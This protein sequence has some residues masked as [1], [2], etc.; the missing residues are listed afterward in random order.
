MPEEVYEDIKIVAL[1][2]VPMC[3]WN[4][5]FGCVHEALRPFGIPL[6]HF[7]GAFWE[8]GISNALEEAVA[9]GVDWVLTL[10]YDTMFTP[11]QLDRLIG[12]FGQSPHMDALTALQCKRGTE[13]VPLMGGF[14]ATKVIDGMAHIEINGQPIK[15]KTAHFGLT[16]LRM[17]SLK[18]VPKPW[19]LGLPDG[20]GSYSTMRRT[21]PDIYFWQQWEK[22]G[23]TIYVDPS[24]SVG[25][26][27][28]TVAEFDENFKP[29]HVHVTDWISKHFAKP[30]EHS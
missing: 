27:Q 10:D 17:D 4:P 23:N 14:T 12:R 29:R 19:L 1:T 5:H 20:D 13:E 8:N 30:V 9:N 6:R 3:G 28:P 26:L 22:A 18:K 24:V 16:L 2:S 15:V 25:H 11:L 7:Y 21:D